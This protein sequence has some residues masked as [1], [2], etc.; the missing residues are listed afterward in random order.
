MFLS[1]VFPI[2][3]L[4]RERLHV[5]SEILMGG[6]HIFGQQLSEN[7]SGFTLVSLQFIMFMIIR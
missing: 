6:G 1:N 3:V 5:V 2:N 7:I 4:D